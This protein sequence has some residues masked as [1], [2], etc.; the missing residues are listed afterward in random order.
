MGEF[1]GES[2]PNITQIK[3]GCFCRRLAGS[4]LGAVCPR[5]KQT[6]LGKQGAVGG[7]SAGMPP[8]VSSDNLHFIWH[9]VH[10]LA[11]FKN[12]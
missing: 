5:E 12:A 6:S 8:T 2:A 1:K 7:H 10:D 9:F 3:A 4:L 11:I